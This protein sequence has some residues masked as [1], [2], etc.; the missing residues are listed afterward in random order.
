[1]PEVRLTEQD[2]G[3]RFTVRASDTIVLQLFQP[4]GGYRWTLERDVAEA[5]DETERTYVPDSDAEGAASQCVLQLRPKRVGTL[6]L[7]L[8][9]RRPWETEGDVGRFVATVDVQP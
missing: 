8:A 1:V 5:F 7:D 9:L 3:G 4:A 6:A 2:T